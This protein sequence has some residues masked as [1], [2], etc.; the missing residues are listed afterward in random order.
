MHLPRLRTASAL[1]AILA[2]AANPAVQDLFSRDGVGQMGI[3]V[4]RTNELRMLSEAAAQQ[5]PIGC[6]AGFAGPYPCE[7]VDILS[8]VPVPQIGAAVGA[9]VWGWTDPETGREIAIPTTTLGAAFVDITP[10]AEGGEPVVLGRLLIGQDDD[11]VLWRDVKVYENHAYVVSEHVGTNLHV[12]DLTRLRGVTSDQGVLEPDTIYTEFSSAHNIGINVDTGF[13]YV[14]GSGGDD[15]EGGLH[16]IDLADPVN[17]AFAGCYADD[18][19]TH[20]VQCEIYAGPD[21]EH[22]GREI[23]LA[24]NEDTVTI[25]DV[26]DKSSPR[27]L[28]RTTYDTASYTHQGWLT[29]DHRW[30]VF[31]DE[32]DELLGGLLN[33]HTYIL[34]IEDLDAPGDVVSYVH[35]ETAIDHN[36]YI[37]DGYIWQA[38]YSAGL[39]IL[40]YTEEGLANGELEQVAYLDVDPGPDAPVFAGAWTAYPFFRSGIVPV[41][42]FDSG[43]FLVRAN[44]PEK[45]VAEPAPEPE[46]EPE[47]AAESEEA[48]PE[49]A[50]AGLPATGGGLA[51]LGLVAVAAGALIRRRR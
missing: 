39:R 18:G 4:E 40:D 30:F 17:P 13:A 19:Y 22:V 31:G 1:L 50:P 36:I 33:T 20:D 51:A 44:L 8:I 49:P 38:N 35:P 29:P 3:D 6:T 48:E 16:M 9:D 41:N 14:V 27:Q 23:C 24:S 43:M 26:T 10:V 46:P 2:L 21:A 15:C 42:S 34:P 45:T 25:I 37:E 7:N 32:T 28:S 47:P 11:N 5:V 12:F